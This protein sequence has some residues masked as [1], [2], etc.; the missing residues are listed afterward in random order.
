MAKYEVG[1][2]VERAYDGEKGVVR[3]VEER[4]IRED[5]FYVKWYSGSED[6][7]SES[8]IHPA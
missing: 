1:E 2:K 4:L 8:E 5:G 7:V 6:W 3:E